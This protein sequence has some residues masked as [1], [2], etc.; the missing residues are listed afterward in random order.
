MAFKMK[1][2]PMKRNFGIEASPIKHPIMDSM[3]VR[4]RD[5]RKHYA[6]VKH[7]P[8]TNRHVTAEEE[9][10]KPEPKKEEVTPIKHSK[11][12]GSGLFA[13]SPAYDRKHNFKYG[14]G[15]KNHETTSDA[16]QDKELIKDIG[17]RRKKYT[18]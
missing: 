10:P 9:T 6:E 11:A 18:K 8:K 2:S 15:H 16:Y 7:D 17:K 3:G 1:G 12:S 13:P 4:P 14:A 5:T